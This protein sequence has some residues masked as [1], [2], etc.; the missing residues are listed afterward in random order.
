MSKTIKVT[1]PDGLWECA[2]Q[3]AIRRGN[4]D[5]ISQYVAG[6]IRAS[7]RATL[8]RAGYRTEE[9]DKRA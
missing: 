6:L 1:L 2:R 3:E 5:T 7:L 8:N 4:G 9:L